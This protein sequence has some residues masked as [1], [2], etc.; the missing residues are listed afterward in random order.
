M[1]T[2]LA[3]IAGVCYGW[4]GVLVSTART[5]RLLRWLIKL[6]PYA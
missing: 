4:A 1:K 3:C 2:V 6:G 5:K